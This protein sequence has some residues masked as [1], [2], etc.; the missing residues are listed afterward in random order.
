MNGFKI[1]VSRVMLFFLG[2]GVKTG[3]R[4]DSV[5][6]TELE[7]LGEGYRVRLK[8]CEGGPSM[9]F[10]TENGKVVTLRGKKSAAERPDLD[11]VFK[12][13]DAGFRVLTGQ[14]GIA[15]SYAE[16]RMLLY[17]DIYKA[18]GVVRIMAKLENYLFPP[19]MT[20]K[21][22]TKRPEKEVSSLRFYFNVVTGL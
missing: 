20:N 6:K 14:A 10:F 17:G 15:R 12:N 7:T 3:Y 21:I 22:L 16:H 19:F 5:V 1:A 18:M 8:T 13:A 4:F 9:T 11:I 2:R